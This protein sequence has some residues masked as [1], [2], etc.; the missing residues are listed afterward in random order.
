MNEN[1]RNRLIMVEDNKIN[2]Y[3]ISYDE[4]RLNEFLNYIKENFYILNRKSIKVKDITKLYD[5]NLGDEIIYCHINKN[6]DQEIELDIEYKMYPTLY[7][8]INEKES[9][10]TNNNIF[11]KLINWLNNN[12]QMS[13]ES[14]TKLASDD[15]LS[16][17]LKEALI[18]ELLSIMNMEKVNEYD[19]EELK[20]QLIRLE[21][22]LDRLDYLLS[23]GTQ[24]QKAFEILNKVSNVNNKAKKKRKFFFRL[25]KSIV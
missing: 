13:I 17:T 2:V 9:Y 12:Y 4:V 20:L 14:K 11:N 18:L 3:K 24:N 15:I 25:R 16:S 6:F 19:I 22:P 5:Y 21:I 8:I 1:G 7:H 23:L 10:D